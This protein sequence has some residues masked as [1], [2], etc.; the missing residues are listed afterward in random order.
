M[1]NHSIASSH[2]QEETPGSVAANSYCQSLQILGM[3]IMSDKPSIQNTIIAARKL[4]DRPGNWLMYTGL[5]RH[6][7]RKVDQK[8]MERSRKENELLWYLHDLRHDSKVPNMV[9][10]RAQL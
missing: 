7:T 2:A 9:N 1:T 3:S 5:I 6:F 4:V 8:Q 10:S